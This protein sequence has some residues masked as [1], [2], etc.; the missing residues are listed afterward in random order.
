MKIHIEAVITID[1]PQRLHVD[2]LPTSLRQYRALKRLTL[3][4]LGELCGLSASALGRIERGQ[5]IP[6][7]DTLAKIEKVLLG[8]KQ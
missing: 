4:Q 5:R 2:D 6:R 8:A 7:S 1:E 3:Q